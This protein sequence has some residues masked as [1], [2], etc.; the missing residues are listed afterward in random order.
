MLKTVLFMV[1]GVS[2]G[3]A[4]ATFIGSQDD[5]LE[6]VTLPGFS[7]DAPSVD[8]VPLT[9]RVGQLEAAL[10]TEIALRESLQQE[11]AALSEQILDDSEREPDQRSAGLGNVPGGELTRAAIQERIA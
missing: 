8:L 4:F 10:A 2:A 7:A 11:L 3:F 1:L 5:Q 9:E 6:D